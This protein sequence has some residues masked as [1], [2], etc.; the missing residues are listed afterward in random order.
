METSEQ[1]ECMKLLMTRLDKGT[2]V[3]AGGMVRNPVDA[4]TSK[5]RAL[6]EWETMF[7]N[8]PQVTGTIPR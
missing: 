8:Y 5:E 3:D 1:I 6:Q 4:Y 2:T 7:R